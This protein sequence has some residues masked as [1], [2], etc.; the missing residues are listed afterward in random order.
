M[1]RILSFVVALSLSVVSLGSG[2]AVLRPTPYP[3]VSA[4][5][6]PWFIRGEAIY[7][8]NNLYFPTGPLVFFDG[9]VMT[10]VGHVESIPLYADVT[11]EQFSMVF[12]PIGNNLMRPYERRRTGELAGTAGSRT[13][14]FPIVRDS[15]LRGQ[16]A[17]SGLPLVF[18]GRV[19]GTAGAPASATGEA[20]PPV[21]PGTAGVASTAGVPVATMPATTGTAGVP[22]VGTVGVA[23]VAR[24][25]ARTPSGGTAG[26]V[27]TSGV[28]PA[29]AVGAS[30]TATPTGAVGTTGIGT[31]IVQRG[32]VATL[33]RAQR[34][35]GIWVMY[36]G[37]RWRSAGEAVPYANDRFVAVGDYRG[38]RVFVPRGVRELNLIYLESTL[39]GGGFLT[40]YRKGT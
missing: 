3:L 33:P 19:V 6:E 28:V 36:E 7:F 39:G 8:A 30:G 27:G 17:P 21:L 37:R 15:E 14:S 12:V 29:G 9:N 25:P 40:P 2:Q 34:T 4:A 31:T 22:I 26:A 16:E 32:G 1:C 11:L 23:P 35:E 24:A 38:F 18:A 5:M 13:P 20:A 10:R